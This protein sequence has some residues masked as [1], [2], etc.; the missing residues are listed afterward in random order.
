MSF[1]KRKSNVKWGVVYAEVR[2]GI[3][4]AVGIGIGGA[5]VAINSLEHSKSEH[6]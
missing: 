3:D 4:F 1:R 2:P 5:D 6:L